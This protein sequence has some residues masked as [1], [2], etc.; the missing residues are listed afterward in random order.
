[1]TRWLARRSPSASYACHFFRSLNQ[2]AEQVDVVVVMLALQNSGNALQPHAGVDRRTRKVDTLILRDLLV[3]H[4]DEVPDLDEAVA[5]F[6]RRAG[7]AAPDMIAVVIEDFRAR[8]ARAGIAHRPE[9]V[10][11]RDADDLVVRQTGDLLPEVK[12]LV[13]RMIDGDQQALGVDSRIPW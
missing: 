7:R 6:F 11:G 4:E 5:V 1:M 9:I 2:S 3:L 12:G 8:A 10:A 13:V